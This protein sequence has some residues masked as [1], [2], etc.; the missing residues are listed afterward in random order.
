MM[1]SLRG[2]VAM[3]TL[4]LASITGNAA[5]AEKQGGILKIE[6]PDSPPSMSIVEEVTLLTRLTMMGVFNNLVMFDQHVKQ[7]S[8]QSIVPDLASS[9]TWNEDG[10]ALTFAL[11]QGVKWHDGRPFIA[12]D[13]QCTWD[14]LLEKSSDKLRV[15]PLKSYYRN[16]EEVSTNGDYEVI[17]HL[18]RPQPAF[19][20]VL[21]D[22]G[23]VIYPCHVPA[24][25][26]RGHPIGTGPFKLVEFKPNESIKLTRNLDYWKRDRPYLDGIEYTIIRDRSTATLA[27]NAGK[28]DMTWDHF[29]SVPRLKDVRSQRPDAICELTPEGGV[30]RHLL[31]NRDVPPFDSPDLRRAMALS[32][33]RKAFI[34][35]LTQGQAEI[36]GV[37]QPPP[38]GLW[39]MPAELLQQLPGYDPDVQKNRAQAERSWRSSAMGPTIG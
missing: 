32:L 38:E 8:L 31:V 7:V 27:F 25:E 6:M 24:R 29:L 22:A 30:N 4:L 12:K 37:L 10:A 17:F 33:D 1:C 39:G 21:A 18:K 5:L 34:D 35:T 20:M 15:N 3:G 36:G 14:L 26:M 2:L 9:W 19:L 13:V 11:R 28:F 23:S 16:V